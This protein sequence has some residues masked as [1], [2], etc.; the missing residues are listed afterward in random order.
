MLLPPKTS[1]IKPQRPRLDA[2]SVTF[3]GCCLTFQAVIV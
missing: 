3:S 2:A 1:G